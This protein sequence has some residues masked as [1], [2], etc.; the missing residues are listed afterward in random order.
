MALLIV[1]LDKHIG[2]AKAW[3]DTFA[4]NLPD[5]AIRI[6]PGARNLPD[7][8]HLAVMHAHSDALP[9]PR[10]PSH[11]QPHGGGQVLRRSPQAAE[12]QAV[13]DRT[14]GGD[15]TVTDYVVTHALR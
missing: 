4:H 2:S 13:H 8:D 14:T 15:P 12:G 10:F 3:R 6:Q 11:V 1:A 5:L 7:I 9:P